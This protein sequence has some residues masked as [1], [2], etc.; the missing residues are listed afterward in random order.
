MK[1]TCLAVVAFGLFVVVQIVQADWTPLKRLTWN[2]GG[3]EYPALAVDSN[4][5][6]HV[7]CRD[8]TPGNLE[9]F[10]MKSPD[11]GLTWSIPKRITWTSKRSN[12]PAIAIDSQGTI[13]VVWQDDAPEDV[14]GIY[15]KRSTDGGTTWSTMKRLTWSWTTGGWSYNP[16]IA[17]DS[18]NIVHVVWN[19]D[20]SGQYELYY[21]RS[22]DGG[23]SWSSLKRI[24]WGYGHHAGASI[25]IGLSNA[26]HAVWHGDVFGSSGEIFYKKST[27][28]G[29]TWTLNKRLT[30][31]SGWSSEPAIAVDLSGQL[32]VVWDDDT[33]GNFDIYHA[34]STDGGDNWTA[35]KR[36]NWNPGNSILPA[37]GTDSF[38]FLHVVWQDNETGTDEILY[39]KS[40]DGGVSWAPVAQGLTYE[41]SGD[42]YRPAIGVD[43]LGNLHV[44]WSDSTPGN[45]EIYYRK[46][47]R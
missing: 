3:S 23:L 37:I 26:I 30:W 47:V 14:T 5:T 46:Y 31:N 41:N 29:A 8:G 19:D 35:A 45:R 2:L 21:K 17:V 10:Y 6:L 36:V 22:S 33:P 12:T 25:I 42:S 28:Q 15:Y 20:A 11:G 18:S 7:V 13:H 39:K 44:V 1:R 38:G 27:D 24:T 16:V 4:S 32:H 34:K 40:P 9:I 43:Y